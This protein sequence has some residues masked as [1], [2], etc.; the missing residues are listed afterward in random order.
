MTNGDRTPESIT[1]P[2]LSTGLS[3]RHLAAAVRNMTPVRLVPQRSEACHSS[4]EKRLNHGHSGSDPNPDR[5]CGNPR[6]ARAKQLVK[7]RG[8]FTFKRKGQ[9]AHDRISQ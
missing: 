3:E 1:Q 6:L 2:A 9:H 4:K 5:I 7:T 8:D